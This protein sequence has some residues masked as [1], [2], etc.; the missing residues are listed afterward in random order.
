M[1][2]SLESLD[3]KVNWIGYRLPTYDIPAMRARTKA[4][5]KWLHFGAGNIFRAFPAVLVQRLMTA[6]LMDS[7]IICCEAYDE[8][9]IDRVYRPF[10]NLAIAVTL[11]ADGFLK[12]EVV[13]SIAESLKLSAEYDRVREIFCASSLQ[14]VTLTVT[15]KAYNISDA[16]MNVLPD[17]VADM[18][19]GPKKAQSFL[20]RLAAL[21][22]DRMHTDRKS[23]V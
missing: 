5:P 9:I 6:G 13:G 3:K 10:D 17:I 1:K 23:V 19:A 4:E 12:K 2:L 22:L 7:G 15:E 8:E 16:Q 21:C 18:K 20:G 14:L 11:H